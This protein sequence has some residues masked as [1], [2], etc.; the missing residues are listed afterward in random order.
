MTCPCYLSLL[1][2]SASFLSFD[3]SL[4]TLLGVRLLALSEFRVSSNISGETSS[5][6]FETLT[7]GRAGRV[8]AAPSFPISFG[9]GLAGRMLTRFWVGKPEFAW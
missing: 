4:F 6:S 8:S 5:F 7:H 9:E 3:F 2:E 1:F